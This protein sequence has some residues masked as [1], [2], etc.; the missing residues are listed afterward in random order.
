MRPKA[1]LDLFPQADGAQEANVQDEDRIKDQ[2]V[3][4]LAQMRHKV[5]ELEEELQLCRSRLRQSREEFKT[6]SYIVSHDLRNPLI[7]L[8]GFAAELEFALE[9]LQPAIDVAL[10]Q[11]DE[12]QATAATTAY[13]EEIPEALSFINSSVS[14]IDNFISAVLKLSR[15]S[16]RELSFEPI[17]MQALVQEVLDSLSNEIEQREAKV[18]VETLPNVI[19][20]RA[21]VKEILGV[22]V[23]NAVIYLTSGRPGEIEIT[24]ERTSDEVVIRV[25]DNGRGIAGDDMHKVF[26]PF[27]RAGR[28]DVPGEGVGLSYVKV[29][30]RRH[31]GRIWCESE[32]GVGTTFTF[33]IPDRDEAPQSEK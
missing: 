20:D 33:T 16:R 13:R 23:E 6:F 9:S 31:G 10:P 27:R 19:A 28:Q 4:E 12:K 22:I 1:Q 30:L 3:S 25:R 24:G 5:H 11:L 26:E 7:N 29:L 2:L 15:L 14:N 32:L 8:K 18:T 17:D 21:S